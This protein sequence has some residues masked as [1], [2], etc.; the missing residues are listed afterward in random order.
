MKE[1]FSKAQKKVWDDYSKEEYANRCKI[2][3]LSNSKWDHHEKGK[4]IWESYSLEK[5]KEIA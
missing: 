1:K 3:K 2:N 5:R 4:K